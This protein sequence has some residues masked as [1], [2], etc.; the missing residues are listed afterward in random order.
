[1][2]FGLF[3]DFKT[4][5]HVHRFGFGN[6]QINFDS[7][8]HVSNLGRKGKNERANIFKRYCQTLF[9]WS[10][11]DVAKLHNYLLRRPELTES[12]SYFC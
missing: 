8:F 4:F 11:S 3:I 5:A 9:H 10:R 6:V 1:M 7:D 12:D 2:R